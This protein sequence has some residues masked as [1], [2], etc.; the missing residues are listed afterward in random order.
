[1]LSGIKQRDNFPYHRRTDM[2]VVNHAQLTLRQ[3]ILKIDIH[4]VIKA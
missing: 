1:M 3:P 4:H 2:A